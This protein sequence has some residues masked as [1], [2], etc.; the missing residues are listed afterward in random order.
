MLVIAAEAKKVADAK[1]LTAWE[2]SLLLCRKSCGRR[3]LHA[4]PSKR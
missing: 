1:V 2:D 4:L 3:G